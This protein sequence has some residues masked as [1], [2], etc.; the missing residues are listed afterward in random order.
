[1]KSF[2]Y[3]GLILIFLLDV[4]GELGRLPVG[5]VNGLLANDLVVGILMALWLIQKTFVERRWP[6]SKLWS[7]FLIFIGIATIALLNGSRFLN[8]N[9]VMVS[10]LY[11]VRFIEYFLIGMMAFD[12]ST[13]EN[14]KKHAHKILNMII[15]SGT[16]LAI[17]GFLQLKFFP[18][19]RRF[20][21][22]G[23]D[24]HINRLL[25][26][27]F[28][29]NF[30]GGL[31][32]FVVSLCLGKSLEKRPKLWLI[33]SSGIMVM[34]LFLTYSRSAYLALLTSIGI[35]GVLR[36]RKILVGALIAGLLLTSV[37]DRAQERVVNLYH[38]ALSVVSDSVELPDATARLRI[39]SWK[40]TLTI[41]ADHPW[42]GVGYN[43]FGFAQ[44]RYGFV[45]DIEHHS[46]SGSDSTFLTI[47]ATT[48]IL[49]F[50]AYLWLWATI[51]IHSFTRRKDPLHLAL[52]AGSMGLLVHSLFVNSLLYTPLLV[53]FYAAIGTIWSRQKHT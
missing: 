13:E 1:M 8:G 44:I 7:P 47:L 46:A 51:L 33:A 30:V 11:L 5:P 16:V 27:W 17:L 43:A 26:T 2:F 45:S 14:D 4:T 6:P 28:D 23:W 36:S 15:V 40:N 39:E 22:E 18:D 3:G 9:E 34:A 32:A 37:S 35:I 21:A 52:F 41:V 42:L 24:P 29:P 38:S 49:G 10:G 20:T 50:S 12:L 25:S 31:L 19:F 48:G 53:F